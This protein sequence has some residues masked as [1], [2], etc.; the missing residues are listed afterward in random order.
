[1]LGSRPGESIADVVFAWILHKVLDC[2]DAELVTQGASES[3][4]AG[5]DPTLWDADEPGPTPLLGPIWADDGAFLSSDPD[6]GRLRDKAGI[7]ARSVLG[8]FFAH[9]LTPN[10]GKGKTE[11]LIT[12][13]GRHSRSVQQ[14][15]F[16]DGQSSL[17]L[18]MGKW[19]TH[20]LRLVT[21]YAHLGCALDRGATMQSEVYR[22]LAR[23]RSA[24]EEHRQRLYQNVRVP[25]HVRGTLFTAMVE[26]TMFNLEVWRDADTNAWTKLRTGHMKLLRRVLAKEVE[27]ETLLKATLVELVA[28]TQHLPLDVLLRVKRLRYVLTLV[29][30][31]PPALW[32]LLHYE[33]RW[34]ASV[35]LDFEWL[36][37][38]DTGTWPVFT[39]ATWPEWWHLL[40]QQP[41]DFRRAIRRAGRAAAAAYALNGACE[42]LAQGQQRD[43]FRHLPGIFRHGG[44]SLWLCGPCRQ[45]FRKKSHLSCHMLRVHGRRAEFRYYLDGTVCKA[46]G[47]DYQRSDKLQAHLSS[48]EK[49][50]PVVKALGVRV[51]IQPGIGS[52]CW[53]L[54][55]KARP[56]LHPPLPADVF[57]VGGTTAE[58]AGETPGEAYVRQ[59]TWRIGA[60]LDAL[61]AGTGEAGFQQGCAEILLG[62]PLYPAEM[63][64]VIDLTISD[65]KMCLDED[66]LEWSIA[67]GSSVL[68]WL[69]TVRDAICGSWLC[70]WAGIAPEA[71]A[72]SATCTP[73]QVEEI[74]RQLSVARTSCSPLFIVGSVSDQCERSL[75]FAEDSPAPTTVQWQDLEMTCARLGPV[76]VI[77]FFQLPGE[78][79]A[80]TCRSTAALNAS[81]AQGTFVLARTLLSFQQ[82]LRMLWRLFLQGGRI[83]MSFA[84]RS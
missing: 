62:F 81:D 40:K 5:C 35:R 23:A 28:W 61:D 51:P 14:A 68:R 36:R 34:K 16:G 55:C 25:L 53:K 69:S 54:S 18:E 10:L 21:E 77:A 17:C 15:V 49:C 67:W 42:R 52:S 6:A 48:S 2:I 70:E 8:A 29:R 39:A 43:V 32:A 31:A 60:W 66:A 63:Q 30:S 13:R 64:T 12:F 74:S 56:T 19:G 11:M 38:Y 83:C 47:K 80:G 84:L 59:C 78:A 82:Q 58:Q 46:C 57:A 3:V 37:K 41:A 24:F 27:P 20:E 1:M 9:G 71:D 73:A 76:A 79:V 75:R 26:S 4:P 33:E 44:G 65:V 50:W 45:V 7:M 72:F 22:R